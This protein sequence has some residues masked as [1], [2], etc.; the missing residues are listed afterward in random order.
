MTN[1]NLEYNKYQAMYIRDVNN[2]LAVDVDGKRKR[3]GAYAHYFDPTNIDI[4]KGD[5]A[6][7]M[8]HSARVIAH[9]AEY[10]LTDGTFQLEELIPAYDNIY[11]FCLRA[12][13]NRSSKLIA[14]E[15]G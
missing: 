8:N 13:V 14:Q 7:H 10:A 12:K 4:G 6:W 3:K 1:L 9:A 15:F 2:Y 11:D 5:L